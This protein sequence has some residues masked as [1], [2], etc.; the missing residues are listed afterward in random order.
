MKKYGRQARFR[1]IRKTA[2]GTSVVLATGTTAAA[3]AKKAAKLARPFTIEQMELGEFTTEEY[4]ARTPH[5][6][7]WTKVYDA[8]APRTGYL[9]NP[10]PGAVYIP[11]PSH[12]SGRAPAR[13]VTDRAHRYRANA[14]PPA[15]PYVCAYCGEGGNLDIEHIDGNEANNDPENKAYACRSCNTT[16]GATFAALEIGTRTNQYN[17]AGA[18]KPASTFN[19]YADAVAGLLVGPSVAAVKL[20]IRT[21]QGTPAAARGKFAVKMGEK[22]RK[23]RRNPEPPTYAQYVYA[24]THHERGAHDEGGKIIHATPKAIRSDYAR[25]IASSKKS[26]GAGDVP[27]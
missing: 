16:K 6:P 4:F 21:M 25:Q 19:E 5:R 9:P 13:I 26:R 10:A 18:R 12:P 7:Q 8:P 15:G 23:A 20:A 11:N 2:G 22:Y 27:F 3:V 14:D 24:V 17:P 1:A